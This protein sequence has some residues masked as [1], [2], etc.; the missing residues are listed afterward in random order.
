MKKYF[1]ASLKSLKKEVESGVGFGSVSQRYLVSLLL[2]EVPVRD[3]NREP[4]GT[5]RQAYALSIALHHNSHST[6][7]TWYRPQ[8]GCLFA[9]VQ[10]KGLI[11]QYK[12]CTVNVSKLNSLY[13]ARSF[14]L[15]F[16]E[17]AT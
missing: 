15:F 6:E 13:F 14:S 4:K 3:S 9:Q 10:L 12:Y 7:K 16:L 5:L 11:K 17:K 8:A 2:R 1:F